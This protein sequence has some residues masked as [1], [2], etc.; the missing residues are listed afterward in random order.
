MEHDEKERIIPAK[1]MHYNLKN[2]C[3]ITT[4]WENFTGVTA[5]NHMKRKYAHKKFQR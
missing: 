3:N 2:K 1:I 5:V 4:K